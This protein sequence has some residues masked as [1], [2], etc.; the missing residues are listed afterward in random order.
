MGSPP[1]PPHERTWRHPSE[2][3]AAERATIRHTEPPRTTRTFAIATGTVGL[4]AVALL[5]FTVT[6]RQ[7]HPAV[8]VATT[9]P[10]APPDTTRL[11]ANPVVA[12][13]TTVARAIP[14][15]LATPIGDG[16]L[17][18]MTLS[19]VGVDYFRRRG[20]LLRAAPT[21]RVS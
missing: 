17:A 6:P 9:S 1:I 12:V 11:H 8:A 15:A 18:L 4:V 7:D 14:R 20:P 16:D 21:T 19:A 2:L 10:I 3:A 5:M 13:T